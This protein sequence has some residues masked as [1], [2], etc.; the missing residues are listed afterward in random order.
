MLLLRDSEVSEIV[1]NGFILG[2]TKAATYTQASVALQ[3]G[4]RL[5]LYTDGIVEARDSAGQMF[6]DER[7]HALAKETASEMPEATAGRIVE[8]VQAW[9]K[10]QD[11]DLT[12]IVCDFTSAMR[13][14]HGVVA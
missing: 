5:I 3:T 13:D 4:D 8:A 12:V 1:E 6:S 10:E 11:D 14:V 2:I 7:L 9:S